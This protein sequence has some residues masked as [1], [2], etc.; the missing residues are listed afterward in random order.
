M[1]TDLSEMVDRKFRKSDFRGAIDSLEKALSPAP[2][3][4][5]KTL[6]GRR[7]TNSS[8]SILSAINDF[9]DECGKQFDVQAVYLEMNGFDINCDRWYFDFF[10]YT[11]YHDDPDDLDWLADWQSEYYPDVTLTGLENIQR[12]FESWNEDHDSNDKGAQEIAVLLVM[13]RFVEL[14]DSALHAGPLTKPVPVLATA[15][16]F[17]IA[18]RWLPRA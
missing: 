11:D 5:F 4:R 1:S 3:G 8:R 7:F 15:H 16:D 12:D 17:D 14:V 6:I 18:G 9:I 13:A 2:G 10:G